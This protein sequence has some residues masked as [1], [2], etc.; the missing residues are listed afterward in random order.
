[1]ASILMP[2]KVTNISIPDLDMTPHIVKHL[3]GVHELTGTA[4]LTFLIAS[5]SRWDTT[6]V[7]TTVTS[8]ITGNSVVGWS[9]VLALDEELT[10]NYSTSRVVSAMTRIYSS[11]IPSGAFALNGRMTGTT[12][13]SN[14]DTSELDPTRL[15]Q[16][17]SGH[18]M[19]S[20][21]IGDG[22]V[23]LHLPMKTPPF[24]LRGSAPYIY[25]DSNVYA[26]DQNAAGAPDVGQASYPSTNVGIFDLSTDPAYL[27]YFR[28]QVRL[29]LDFQGDISVAVDPVAF[30]ITAK[31]IDDT[32]TLQTAA[33]TTIYG[34]RATTVVEVTGTA[35]LYSPY[36]VAQI[37]ISSNATISNANAFRFDAWSPGS[38]S[39][40]HEVPFTILHIA[41]IDPATRVSVNQFY[42]YEA[43]PSASLSRDIHARQASSSYPGELYDAED[44]L[45]NHP[46]VV[47]IYA[48]SEYTEL[49]RN[50][51]SYTSVNSIRTHSAMGW[52]DVGKFARAFGRNLRRVARFTQPLWSPYLDSYS[53]GLGGAVSRAA[54]IHSASSPQ[55]EINLDGDENYEESEAAVDICCPLPDQD[56]SLE[57]GVSG[58]TPVLNPSPLLSRPLSGTSLTLWEAQVAERDA[59]EP[60]VPPT[61]TNRKGKPIHTFTR[62]ARAPSQAKIKKWEKRRKRKPQPPQRIHQCMDF[63]SG[64]NFEISEDEYETDDDG[65]DLKDESPYEEEEYYPEVPA[66]PKPERF[67]NSRDVISMAANPPKMLQ[68]TY[69]FNVGQDLNV[70]IFISRFPTV[71]DNVTPGLVLCSLTKYKVRSD[72]APYNYRLQ[73][74]QGLDN[75]YVSDSVDDAVLGQ[76]ALAIEHTNFTHEGKLYLSFTDAQTGQQAALV[77]ASC[78]LSIY[79][80]FAGIPL[81]DFGLTG[82]LIQDG[83]TLALGPVLGVDTKLRAIPSMHMAGSADQELGKSRYNYTVSELLAQR[84]LD[85][86]QESGRPRQIRLLVERPTDLCIIPLLRAITY[87]AVRTAE[88]K[89]ARRKLIRSSRPAPSGPTLADP[90]PDMTVEVKVGG[91]DTTLSLHNVASA[92]GVEGTTFYDLVTGAAGFFQ[93]L[94]KTERGQRAFSAYAKSLRDILDSANYIRNKKEP[95]SQWIER[96]DVDLSRPLKS[97]F[98]PSILNTYATY[99]S[100]KGR[101]KKTRTKKKKPRAPLPV[102]GGLNFL[103]GD[104]L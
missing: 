10:D 9:Q 91:V 71:V 1:L 5:G 79:C 27:G 32:G 15:T 11:T 80:V 68:A 12:L 43:L 50:S 83:D 93:N 77:G 18:A 97:T 2:D 66:K 47:P 59:T 42:N 37:L 25:D 101:G 62:Y 29:S 6:I 21:P 87:P 34:S 54:R 95:R 48:G 26:Y 8:P 102:V 22:V 39:S 104:G 73:P 61:P 35:T 55:V 49:L 14:I 65:L 51:A 60:L 31:Y 78:G 89:Q 28:G 17:N 82:V 84:T 88:E 67:Y 3:I 96:D 64:G 100:M 19:A 98:I 86:R 74:F 90:Y 16:Y 56:F 103:T 72:D 58:S 81:F 36:P 53:P 46:G 57:V 44:S 70:A 13:Y 41:G 45:M 75:L 69:L 30:Y 40:S 99:L 52:S 33:S 76:V 20:V 7:G 92:M 38:S 23:C 63:L 4:D 24:S 85:I 94:T